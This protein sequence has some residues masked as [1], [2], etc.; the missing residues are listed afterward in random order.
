MGY[1]LSRGTQQLQ[2]NF[3]LYF[4]ED[5]HDRKSSCFKQEESY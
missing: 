3:I 1:E 4:T 5:Q 2:H